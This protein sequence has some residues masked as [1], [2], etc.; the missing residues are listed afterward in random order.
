[1][2]KIFLLLAIVAGMAF[3]SCEGDPGPQGPEGLPGR[4]SEVFE[5]KNVNFTLA[6]NEYSIYRTLDPVIRPADVILIYRLTGTIDPQ[7][8][9]WQ[10]IPQTLYLNDGD[11]VDYNYDFSLEDFTIYAGGNY[12][13]ATTPEYLNNQTFRI[14]IVPGYFSKNV[15]TKNF[16]AV[17]SALKLTEDDF[18]KSAKK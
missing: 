3:T 6:N 14:V 18:R 4:E 5:L 16:E 10:L 11:E 9:I 17:K 15:D 2:K 8:P 7:T 12:N 1:M 13:I